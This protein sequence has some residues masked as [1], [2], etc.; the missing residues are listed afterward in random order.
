M[1]EDLEEYC[2]KCFEEINFEF[3]FVIWLGTLPLWGDG[4][5]PP[6][7]LSC[8]ILYYI[9]LGYVQ[10]QIFREHIIWCRWQNYTCECAT[11]TVITQH[12]QHKFH[13]HT[14]R[15]STDSPMHPIIWK[16]WR[17]IACYMRYYWTGITEILLLGTIFPHRVSS[18]EKNM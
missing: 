18:K 8:R 4:I 17:W 15:I 2:A 16:A 13:K 5:T 14:K 12:Q 6:R 10:L 3:I 7:V 11:T 1:H 9:C